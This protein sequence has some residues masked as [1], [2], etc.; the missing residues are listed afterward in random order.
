ME[1]GLYA[2]NT[3]SLA[4][5]RLCDSL[6]SICKTV[7]FRPGHAPFR[8]ATTMVASPTDDST[9][10]A[11]I[12]KET[13][14]FD[15]TCLATHVPYDNNHFFD[16]SGQRTIV[17]FSGWNALTD[18]PVAN[19]FVYF[20]ASILA[21]R[22]DVGT[23][24][25]EN[26]GCLND[27]WWDKSGVDV[28]MR[29]AYICSDCLAERTWQTPE[30]EVISDVQALLDAVS[31]ASRSGSDVL[32]A[33]SIQLLSERDGFDVFLCH[34]SADKKA[35]RDINQKM[36]GAGVRTW[37]DEEQ[38]QPGLPW[39]PELE[40]QIEK[41]RSA[42]VFVGESGFGPWQENE[43]RAF[44]DEF[45]AQKLPVIPVLLPDATT[46]PKLPIFL[47]QRT[48]IDLRE[49]YDEN[50]DRLIG[51]LGKDRPTY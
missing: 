38:L 36:K 24:H 40:R 5:D 29:A 34:N 23:T 27:F 42:C 26:T 20:I 46:V 8:L 22:I 11:A 49:S 17:S 33:R 21:H 48:W 1:V 16:S 15:F 32:N 41:V 12:L 7:C 4:V 6:N 35:V 31:H 14:D 28:G 10:S 43:T 18:L 44:L 25:H 37:L 30:R 19:G 47:K 2:D 3:L 51:F 39:Q 13:T 50:L 9:L 45:D